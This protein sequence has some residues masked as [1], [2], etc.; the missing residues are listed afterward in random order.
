MAEKDKD[1]K[2]LC[3]NCGHMICKFDYSDNMVKVLGQFEVT[4]YTHQWGYKC[5]VPGCDC[6]KPEPIE[7]D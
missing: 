4:Q 5:M 7:D 3:K 2:L 6:R 1:K